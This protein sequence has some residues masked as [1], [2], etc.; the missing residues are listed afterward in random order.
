MEP[1]TAATR[2]LDGAALC[3]G[4]LTAAIGSAK[5][6]YVAASCSAAS[7]GNRRS[8]G[9]STV[10]TLIARHGFSPLATRVA[11]H[12]LSNQAEAPPE[13]G[14]WRSPTPI[15]DCHRH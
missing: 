5:W 12:A 11:T 9:D 15:A 10:Y 7:L 2:A 1:K 4:R 13:A 6:R 3:S 14:E 8:V